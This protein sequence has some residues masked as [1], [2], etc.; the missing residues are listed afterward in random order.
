M[1]VATK[2]ASVLVLT[3][4][5]ACSDDGTG[6]GNS[7]TS[8]STGSAEVTG[9]ES[10]SATMGMSSTNPTTTAS[11]TASTTA[12]SADS[13]DDSESGGFINPDDE[14]GPG[15]PGPNGAQC[16]TNEE[17]ESGYCYTIPMVGGVCS[18]CLMDADCE[19]G[20]C[21]LDAAAMYAVCTDGS[22]GS[23]CDSDE[24]CMGDLV[25]TELIDTMGL[26]NANYCSECGE[27]A[28]CEGEQVCSPTYDADNFSGYFTCVDPG[29]VPNGGGCPLEGG[30]GDGTPCESGHCGA[31]DLFMGFVS[32]GVCGEC[33]TDEDCMEGQT[34]TPAS[35]DGGLMG[36]ICE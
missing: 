11:T 7:D 27:S 3:S 24:G 19:M 16:G 30:M 33:T 22:L 13:G 8:S 4:V 9:D 21:A 32:L 31:A 25:C 35:G 12:T 15:A 6:L 26:F 14:S 1:H 20:T 2:I 28:P 5:L 36:A 18:E 10:V 23:M 29:S 34:C 17:C